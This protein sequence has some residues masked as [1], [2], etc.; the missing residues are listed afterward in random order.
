MQCDN[1]ITNAASGQTHYSQTRSVEGSRYDNNTLKCP[2][3]CCI[4]DG[5]CVCMLR[6]LIRRKLRMRAQLHA[7]AQS[8]TQGSPSGSAQKGCDAPL[9]RLCNVC[10]TN[11]QP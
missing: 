8:S 1:H 7:S 3:L 2:C 10:F 6:S 9:L 11:E 5:G 4:F